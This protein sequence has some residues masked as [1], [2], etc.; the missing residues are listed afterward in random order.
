MTLLAGSETHGIERSS[1][2]LARRI[3]ETLSP[4]GSLPGISVSVRTISGS[5]VTVVEGGNLLSLE[6]RTSESSQSEGLA[7]SFAL[8]DGFQIQVGNANENPSSARLVCA[9]LQSSLRALESERREVLFL[10]ELGTNWESLEAL[11][12]ISTEALRYGNI[13][14]ALKRL[15]D[16]L[17]VLQEGLHAALFIRREGLYCPLMGAGHD[18]RGLTLSQ[19]GPVKTAVEEMRLIVVNQLPTTPDAGAC[20]RNA[21][22]LA[23]APFA[24]GGKPRV[25]CG[26]ERE[27]AWRDGFFRSSH[28][29]SD[30]LP[31]L[32]HD[33]ERPAQP[34]SAGKRTAC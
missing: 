1:A 4:M 2:T 3:H 12:E 19:L 20:W 34:Q 13:N 24:W 27:Q 30:D 6:S 8:E 25:R 21:L 29:G 9:L 14:D 23:A 31:G 5:T 16:R 17:T 22:N 28:A 18:L 33:A 10:E 26:L 15:M 7:L 11:Y 32:R